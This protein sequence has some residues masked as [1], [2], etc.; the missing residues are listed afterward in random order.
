MAIPSKSFIIHVLVMGLLAV[1][2]TLIIYKI[3]ERRFDRPVALVASCLFA[4]MPATLILD[5]F[6]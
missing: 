6:I 1:I 4:V 3:A 5:R 2:D